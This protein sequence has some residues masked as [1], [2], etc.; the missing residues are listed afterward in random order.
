[1]QQN[2]P[3]MATLVGQRLPGFRRMNG[4]VGRFGI[5]IGP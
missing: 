1:M 5:T 4:S 2:N 3:H